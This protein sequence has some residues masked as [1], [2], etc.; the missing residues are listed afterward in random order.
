MTDGLCRQ[1][2]AKVR[3]EAIQKALRAAH[4]GVLGV[5]ERAIKV[6]EQLLDLFD[7]VHRNGV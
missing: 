5:K 4:A 1:R 2:R 3:R 7:D 6:R